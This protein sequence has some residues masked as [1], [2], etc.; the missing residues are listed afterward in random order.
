MI[1]TTFKPC[2]CLKALNIG[3]YCLKWYL[4]YPSYFV[5]LHW[6]MYC[7]TNN[8][9]YLIQLYSPKAFFLNRIVFSYLDL[10]FRWTAPLCQIIDNLTSTIVAVKILR[11]LVPDNQDRQ[12]EASHFAVAFDCP[13]LLYFGWLH[14]AYAIH[15]VVLAKFAGK[16]S[17]NVIRLEVLLSLLLQQY[18]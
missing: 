18:Q 16:T 2:P 1:K 17:Q 3:W 13:F 7:T 9:W 6:T 14:H 15:R 5:R 11:R 10:K 12:F 4:C 8:T